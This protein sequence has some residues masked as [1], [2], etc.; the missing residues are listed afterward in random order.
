MVIYMNQKENT[1]ERIIKAASK[2]FAQKGFA[3]TTTQEIC[4][5]ASANIAA[6]NYHFG[7]KGNLYRMVWKYFDDLESKRIAAYIKEDA[8]PEERL[9]SFVKMRVEETL[10]DGEIGYLPRLVRREMGDPSIFHE[11]L[12]N[13]VIEKW[14]NRA[15]ELL[16]EI[17][18][19]KI[20]NHALHVAGFCAFSPMIHLLDILN[21]PHPPKFTKKHPHLE[22]DPDLLVE[23]LCTFA[24]AGLREVNRKVQKQ[25]NL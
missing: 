22:D 6:V 1:K 4:D 23:M 7:G 14:R 2:L 12:H 21:N 13:S 8:S 25:G 15:T 10:S 11:E 24:L 20:D 9:R 5:A 3:K 19:S 18:G 17:V 16:R